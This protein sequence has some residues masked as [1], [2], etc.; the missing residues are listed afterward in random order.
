MM[1]K[2]LSVAV[3]LS[4]GLIHGCADSTV[5]FE[6]S[7]LMPGNGQAV[8]LK[9]TESKAVMTLRTRT[10]EYVFAGEI[11]EN[12]ATELR[13]EGKLQNGDQPVAE[14]FKLYPYHTGGIWVCDGCG[15][16]VEISPVL[17]VETSSQ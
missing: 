8:S 7:P 1:M 3:A 16:W 5:A 6:Q 11:A 12:S 17:M 14:I 13:F 15:P 9:G 2:K 10:N 4:A